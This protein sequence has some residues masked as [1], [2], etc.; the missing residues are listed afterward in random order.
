MPPKKEI[1]GSVLLKELIAIRTDT[2]WRMLS[3]LQQ[4][5]L[6]E[7]NEEGATGKLDNKGAIFIPGGLVYQDVDR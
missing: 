1:L 5:Q 2:L 3:L 4:D 6:P 7:V